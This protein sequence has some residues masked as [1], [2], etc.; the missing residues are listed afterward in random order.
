LATILPLAMGKTKPTTLEKQPSP[1]QAFLQNEK[2]CN[3]N[4]VGNLNVCCR[5]Q[6]KGLCNQ[7][8]HIDSIHLKICMCI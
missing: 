3:Q 5:L 1:Y 6:K 4:L 8:K 7:M 2:P